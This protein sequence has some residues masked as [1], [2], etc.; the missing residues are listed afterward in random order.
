MEEDS[1]VDSLTTYDGIYEGKDT[2]HRCRRSC[3]HRRRFLAPAKSN[4]RALSPATTVHEL[5][6]CPVCSKSMFP[7]IHQC[8]NGHILAQSAS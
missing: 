1:F 3:H 5:L 4:N 6:E 8:P 2:Y 7:P